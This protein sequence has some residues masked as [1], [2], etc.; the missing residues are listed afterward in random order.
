MGRLSDATLKA[1]LKRPRTR[2]TEI[3]DGSVPGLGVRVG[4]GRAATW[5]LVLR[6]RGEGG[7][8]RRGFAKKGRRYRFTL[9]N[10][11]AMSLEEARARAN[12]FR[13]QANAG[14]SPVITLERAAAAGSLTVEALSER[15]LEDYA[16]S[17]NL[18]S[19][20]KYAQAIATHIVPNVGHLLVDALDRE[21]VRNLIRQVRVRRPRPD[22]NRGRA[23]GGTEAARRALGV[24][25][26]MVGWAIDERLVDRQDN[27]ASGMEKNLPR[28]NR[29][30][31]RGDRI[32][33]LQDTRLVW[34]AANSGFAFDSHAR[35]MLLTGCRAGEWAGARWPWVDFAQATLTIPAEY[36]KSKHV[37]VVPLVPEAML[38]L[39]NIYRGGKG[40]YILSTTDGEKPIRGLAK[41]YQA[42][43]PEAIVA[44]QGAPFATRFTSHDLRRTV[45]TQ[46]GGSLGLG[47]EL[48]VKRILGHSDGSATA[49]YNRYGYLK[50][51]RAALET[52]ARELT[53]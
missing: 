40:D 19:T 15:F 45:A 36:Y 12:E 42:R 13:G 2:Q 6:I 34:R 17:K 18:R 46:I 25:R 49:I 43:L 50:E 48:L 51:M 5:S 31:N 14:E 29:R 37:H 35:L 41:Y 33:T 20:Q 39:E 9:G 22:T 16:R 32:L 3:M 7:V 8:S 1:E 28:K 11:P 4:R 53:Q 30:K 38:I 10:Y 26:L 52:W 21:H 24:L 23:R 44:C 47:G 27:C